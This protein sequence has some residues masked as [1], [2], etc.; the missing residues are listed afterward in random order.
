[1]RRQEIRLKN[2]EIEGKQQH[3][4]FDFACYNVC[5]ITIGDCLLNIAE[6]GLSIARDRKNDPDKFSTLATL[7]DLEDALDKGRNLLRDSGRERKP[8]INGKMD[9][10]RKE[11]R[12]IIDG[13]PASDAK[14]FLETRGE[15]LK[16]QFF[17]K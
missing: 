7:L 3:A 5:M 13:I 1:L 11:I 12:E 15:N 8:E 9:L 2:L 6:A 10:L 14:S 4:L 16:T 17:V